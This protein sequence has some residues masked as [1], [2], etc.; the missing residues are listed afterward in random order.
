MKV[1]A[2]MFSEIIGFRDY[3]ASVAPQLKSILVLSQFFDGSVDSGCLG[4]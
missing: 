1:A 3:I 2:G 4:A